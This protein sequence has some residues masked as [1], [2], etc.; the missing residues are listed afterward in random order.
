MN[1][2][3]RR[4]LTVVGLVA[5]TTLLPFVAAKLDEDRRFC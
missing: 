3:K 1:K 4:L 2:S 5:L